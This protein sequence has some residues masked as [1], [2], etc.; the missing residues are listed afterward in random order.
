LSSRFSNLYQ[1]SP[2]AGDVEEVSDLCMGPVAFP[3]TGSVNLPSVSSFATA[4]K[5]TM[6]FPGE[7]R[8]A[9]SSGVI[10]T[11]IKKKKKQY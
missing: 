1:V 7:N 4:R 11:V 8:P 5:A 3:V 2:L 6:S 10:I 9:K